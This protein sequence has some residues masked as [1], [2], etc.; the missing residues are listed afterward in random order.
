MHNVFLPDI[1]FVIISRS[2]GVTVM[3]YI[4]VKQYNIM[5]VRKN[6]DKNI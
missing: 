4:F 5:Y 2:F 6:G 3:P 1:H